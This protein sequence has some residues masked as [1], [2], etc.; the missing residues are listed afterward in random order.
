MFSRGDIDKI[1]KRSMAFKSGEVD[2]KSQ[3]PSMRDDQFVFLDQLKNRAKPTKLRSD[4]GYVLRMFF[5]L[6]HIPIF[7]LVC[8]LYAAHGAEV[9]PLVLFLAWEYAYRRRRIKPEKILYHF[10]QGTKDAIRYAEVSKRYVLKL[11]IKLKGDEWMPDKY[12]YYIVL[13]HGFSLCSYTMIPRG[14]GDEIELNIRH[15]TFIDKVLEEIASMQPSLDEKETEFTKKAWYNLGEDFFKVYGPFQSSDYSVTNTKRVA[16]LVQSTGSTVAESVVKFQRYRNYWEKVLVFAVGS[17]LMDYLPQMDENEK[18]HKP[19]KLDT[20][21]FENT[22][23]GGFKRDMAKYRWLMNRIEREIFFESA[24]QPWAD[25]GLFNRPAEMVRNGNKT[26]LARPKKKKAKY[27]ESSDEYEKGI[28]VSGLSS[29]ERK[30]LL[31]SQP[32]YPN[33]VVLRNFDVKPKTRNEKDIV[34]FGLHRLQNEL[35]EHILKN[36]MLNDFDIIVCS[37]LWGKFIRSILE[38]DKYSR[39]SEVLIKRTRLHIEL[40]DE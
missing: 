34:I 18:S 23:I 9:I 25:K 20:K 31:N 39:D 2:F 4:D 21:V 13:Q 8:L 6:T 33:S 27:Q 32:F 37:G 35:A 10:V 29:N 7:F 30:K 22:S 19:P 12:G 15:C 17:D 28:N 14:H 40:F 5:R 36:L 1:R 3:G 38:R 16:V 11:K 24:C 26:Y